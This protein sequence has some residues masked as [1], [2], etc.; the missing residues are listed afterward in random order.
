MRMPEGWP[1]CQGC[2][3]PIETGRST[4]AW[5]GRVILWEEIIRALPDGAVV[6]YANNIPAMIDIP[7]IPTKDTR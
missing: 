3:A 4:C 5:C 7:R 1:R 6:L 2:G